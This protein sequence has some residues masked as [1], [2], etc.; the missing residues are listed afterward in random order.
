MIYPFLSLETAE[1]IVG[2]GLVLLHLIAL[3]NA[4][5]VKRWLRALPRSSGMGFFFLSIDAVW[6]FAMVWTMD[7]GEFQ[8]WRPSLLVFIPIAYLLT[9][10][11]VDELLAVRA[12]GILAL[13]AAEPIL[14]AAFLQEP[15]SRLLL[16]VLAYVWVVAGMFWVGSPYLM[17]DWI[18]WLLRSETRW[19]A[20]CVA[21]LAYGAAVLICSATQ[22][23]SA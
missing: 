12:L 7:L 5:E 14:E 17:R 19:K 2:C 3:V 21:G 6:A 9:L 18:S 23:H 8:H 22:H 13:L 11:Y 15:M 16:V 4:K 1:W 10:K 20:L